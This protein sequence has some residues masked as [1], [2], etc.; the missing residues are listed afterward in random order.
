MNRIRAGWPRIRRKRAWTEHLPADPRDP[1]VVRA[2]A[3][4]RA[5]PGRPGPTR[6]SRRTP[7]ALGR[8]PAPRAGPY[9]AGRTGPVTVHLSRRGRT[10]SLSIAS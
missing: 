9:T 6:L 7:V 8:L 5:R 2:K 10:P 4:A 3:L 1:D